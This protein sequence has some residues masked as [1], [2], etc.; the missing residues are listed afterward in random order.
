METKVKFIYKKV[1]KK[2]NG[3]EYTYYYFTKNQKHFYCSRKLKNVEDF[4]IRFA[5]KNN[6]QNIYK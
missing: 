3:S 4:V 2:P 1:I 5:E 6:I